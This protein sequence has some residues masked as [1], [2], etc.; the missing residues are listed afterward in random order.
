[1]VMKLTGTTFFLRSNISHAVNILVIKIKICNLLIFTND[2][3]YIISILIIDQFV[4]YYQNYFDN[5]IKIIIQK[6]IILLY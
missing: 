6:Y 5:I 2:R 4:L 1:M 3:K